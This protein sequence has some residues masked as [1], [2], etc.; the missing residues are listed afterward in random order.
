MGLPHQGLNPTL[1][2]WGFT[3][4]SGQLMSMCFQAFESQTEHNKQSL[5]LFALC[6]AIGSTK[7]RHLNIRF[8]LGVRVKTHYTP[9]KL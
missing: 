8:N 2:L 7:V 6:Q 3:A 1:M 5:F 4:K 9:Q